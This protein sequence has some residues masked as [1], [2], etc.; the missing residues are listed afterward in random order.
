MRSGRIETSATIF[1]KAIY[2]EALP[3]CQSFPYILTFYLEAAEVRVHGDSRMREI[4]TENAIDKETCLHIYFQLLS[5]QSHGSTK[6]TSNVH[7]K[8]IP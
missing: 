4:Q 8:F 6:F 7:S 2:I 1:N 5:S 3:F